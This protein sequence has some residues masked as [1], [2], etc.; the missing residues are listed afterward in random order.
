MYLLVKLQ[1]T[2]LSIALL[3][4]LQLGLRQQLQPTE[5]TRFVPRAMHHDQMHVEACCTTQP[6]TTQ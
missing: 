5:A 1:I 3:L 6:L 2:S 4:W